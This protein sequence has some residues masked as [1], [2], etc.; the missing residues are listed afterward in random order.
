MPCA[1]TPG[2]RS[3]ASRLLRRTGIALVLSAAAG[4]AAL[5]APPPGFPATTAPA[6][7]GAPNIIV[8]MTDDVGFAASSTFGGGVPTPTF[9][10]L[11]DD[12]LRYANFHTT[13]LCSPSRAA[14]L[15]GRNHHAV[16]YGGVSEFARGEPGYSSIIP[17]SAATIGQ[18]LKAN[19]YD[20]AW[21]G[22]NHNVPT[23][24]NGPLGPFDQWPIGLGFGYFYGFNGGHTD[25]FAPALIENTNEIEAPRQAGYIL[26]HDLADHAIQWLQLQ[27]AQG[28]GRPF[29]MYYAP[30]TAHS[31]LQAPPEWLA[32]F[33]GKFDAGWDVYRQQAF[34]RQKRMGI[35][36]ANARLG[37]APPGVKPWDQLT[38][39][40][41]KVFARYMEAYAAA[42][43][44]CDDQF[45]RVVE[46]L[47]QS[48]QL[49]NTL[50]VYIQ[51]DNGA[52]PEGGPTGIF[53]YAGGFDPKASFDYA[54]SHLDE[55]GGPKSYAVAPV[56]WAVAMDTPY[57]YY[58]LIASRLGGTTNGMVVSWPKKIAARGVRNQF[59][60]LVDIAPT[61]LEAAGV[62]PPTT[63]NGV[64]Q[65]PFDGVSFTYSFNQPNAASRHRTQYFEITGNAAL[66]QDG[67]LAA[68][69][70]QPVGMVRSPPAALAERWQL[71]DLRNDPTQTTDVAEANPEKLKQL[72]QAFAA[73]ARRNHV[74]PI[75]NDTLRLLQPG[76]R[77]EVMASSGP[78]ILYPS[79][80]LYSGGTFPNLNNRSW[81]IEA[82][83]EAPKDGGDG[84]LI[85]EGGQFAGWGLVMLH[86]APQ[87]LY[88]TSNTAE[89]LTRLA[90][91]E[92]LAPGPH[93][94]RVE[95][96]I[97]GPGLGRGG[98]LRM[99]VDGQQV[100]SGRL[101]RSIPIDVGAERAAVGHDSE[102]ALTD[103][104][105]LPSRYDG[106]LR[107]VTVDLQ[108]PPSPAQA[109]A[110]Q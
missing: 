72:R 26:D 45:G 48:G 74:L 24:Q 108:P 89:S 15:T 78:H 9:D 65:A 38:P 76:N 25:Q 22:K 41:K 61:L 39:D 47:R 55:I 102:T 14:L 92:R 8:M 60:H 105:V 73:E 44:Y 37:P 79:T 1:T 82:E 101:Q 57:P 83:L 36:P 3:R 85:T 10:H 42:L 94:V 54:L 16:G 103:D 69:P 66:Y 106:V 30:G 6:P 2:R 28:G 18:I 29:F 20:T 100:A 70:V 40:E 56:G 46:T 63:L 59:T 5:A 17:K 99:T 13:A 90:A 27:H 19:G 91:P 109:T 43:A 88:R 81:S 86:G 75:S 12:G 34:E 58:K 68:S 104:Y 84:V 71:Y 96:A 77:P 32:K 50:I 87:F 95:F 80:N 31:P 49:D 67:W 11:A 53:N 62:K 33:R 7:A 110:A 107:Q 35:I 97:D 98:A 93:K 52:T 21:L 51:G 23:W 4:A 64:A